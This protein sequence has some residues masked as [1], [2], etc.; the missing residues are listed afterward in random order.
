MSTHETTPEDVRDFLRKH[1][2]MVLSINGCGTGGPNTSVMHYSVGNSIPMDIYFG[3]R[4]S[5]AK[6]DLLEKDNRV[7]CIVLEE[8]ND[9][10]RA[11]SIH[12]TARKI[13]ADMEDELAKAIFRLNNTTTWYIE[14]SDD[15]VM[16]AIRPTSIRFLDGSSGTLKVTEVEL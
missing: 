8:T 4:A 5:F 10:I 15:I 16:Y 12:G 13:D 6:H 3:T 11:V 1:F 9:P 2:K 14:G 7:S